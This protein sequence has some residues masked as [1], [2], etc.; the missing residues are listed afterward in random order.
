MIFFSTSETIANPDALNMTKN[1]NKL[2]E[3]YAFKV[4]D[5]YLNYDPCKK[6]R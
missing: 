2:Y 4:T 3:M 5:E 1:L 6:Q